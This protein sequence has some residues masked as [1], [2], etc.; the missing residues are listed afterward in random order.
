LAVPDIAGLHF[1]NQWMSRALPA[2]TL[3]QLQNCVG[4]ILFVHPT[5][6]KPARKDT[7]DGDELESV[8][9]PWDAAFAPTQVRLVDMLQAAVTETLGPLL[10]VAIVISAWD[11]V[12]PGELP[13]NWL[14]RELPLLDQFLAANWSSVSARVYGVSA[15]GGTLGE[16]EALARIDSPSSRV[17]VAIGSEITSDLTLPLHFLLEDRP[18]S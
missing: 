17:R 13:A 5:V 12:A 15:I 2:A 9:V 8:G 6:T 18:D 11:T 4:V 10:R 16:R 7:G 3:E 1:A 14:K